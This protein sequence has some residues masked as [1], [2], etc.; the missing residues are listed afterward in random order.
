MI[1]S[2]RVVGVR[3]ERRTVTVPRISGVV[4]LAL[5][6]FGL[7]LLPRVLAPGAFTT[8]DEQGNWLTRS[9]IFLDALRA[10][11]YDNTYQR[12]HPGVTT[13]WLGAAGMWAHE[14]LLAAGG[15]TDRAFF[16]AVIRFPVA[17]VCALAVALAYPLLRRLLD[18]RVALLAVLFLA[19]NPFLVAHAKILH[20]DALLTAFVLTVLLTGLVAFRLDSQSEAH[21]HPVR[22]GMLIASAVA[23]GLAL[24]TRL[25]PAL[26][27]IPLIGLAALVGGWCYERRNADRGGRLWRILGRLFVALL[28][29]SGVVLITVFAAW[30]ALWVD[31]AGVVRDLAGGFTEGAEA[32]EG[33]NFFMGQ[34]VADPGPWF[35]PVAI[36]LRLT[37]WSLIG[38]LLTVIAGGVW[39]A[40]RFRRD[41][42]SRTCRPHAPVLILL[43]S[44]ALLFV[45]GISLAAKKFDRYA[46]PVFPMLDIL[47]ATGWIWFGTLPMFQRFNVSMFQ[48]LVWPAVVLG[49]AAHLAWYHPYE[50]AYYNPLLGGGPVAERTLL[51][52]WGEG[53]DHAGAYIAANSPDCDLPVVSGYN[54]LIEPFICNPIVAH[55]YLHN[56]ERGGYAVF[57]IS[58]RQRQHWQTLFAHLAQQGPPVHVVRIHGIS[59]ALIYALEPPV[60]YPLAAD[61]GPAMHLRGYDLD[62]TALRASDTLTLTLQWQP[63]AR[64]TADYMLFIHVLDAQGRRVG[65]VDVPPGGLAEPTSRWNPNDHVRLIQPIPLPADL[66]PGPY[67]I[68]LGAY[69]PQTLERLPLDT[70]VVHP[71]APPVSPETLL[72]NPIMLP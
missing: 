9:Q 19:V 35:Y 29:W 22:W 66:P 38:L 2:G 61:F 58:H 1:E 59:Y 24:L 54:F 60:S 20:V 62:T 48:W 30:P 7:A 21:G 32:H 49:L 5:L 23:A 70:Q 56:P 51:I 39:V 46:L 33:G 37:P 14:K 34:A 69:H 68:A 55:G 64:L 3:R 53:L 63:R 71:D 8:V 25:L 31:P 44:F 4:L 27:L 52:G 12:Y 11:D 41:P 42:R 40:N 28:V 16:W 50:L 45:V 72:L 6:V 10:G 13:M 65:Q 43:A 36:A 67:W 15:P 47:A 26:T 18:R 57:Y 17:L